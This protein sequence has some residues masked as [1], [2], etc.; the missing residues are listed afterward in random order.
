MSTSFLQV[1]LLFPA[2]TT[3]QLHAPCTYLSARDR[4]YSGLYATCNVPDYGKCSFLK[5]WQIVV[6]YQRDITNITNITFTFIN[7]SF[8]S[9]EV[10]GLRLEGIA[11]YCQIIVI[12]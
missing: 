9:K 7:M 11:F 1:A 2:A 3:P 4:I 10:W 5:K 12:L 8:F 6:V